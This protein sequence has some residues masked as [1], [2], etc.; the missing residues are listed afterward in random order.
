MMDTRS[1]SI[2][3]GIILHLMTQKIMSADAIDKALN[4]HSGLLGISGISSDMRDTIEKSQQ[5]N[6]RASLAFEI[7]IHRLTSCLGAMVAS[8]NGLDLLIF[9]AGIGENASLLRKRVCD[10]L[11]FLG[12]KL[13]LKENENSSD[14]DR[15]ISLHDSQVT[16]MVLHTKEALQIARECKK[17]MDGINPNYPSFTPTV[18]H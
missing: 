15:I 1:G 2:D 12:V 4:H 18:S 8:L 17:R 6:E 7:Y 16:V 3:P 9:T 13:D 11:S 10:N 14:K 5:G